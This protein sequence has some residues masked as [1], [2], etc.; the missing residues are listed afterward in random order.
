MVSIIFIYALFPLF[1]VPVHSIQY[2]TNTTVPSNISTA[3][4]QALIGDISCGEL[5]PFLNIGNYYTENVLEPFC[6]TDC[7]SA[8]GQYQLSIDEACGGE[9]WEGYSDNSSGDDSSEDDRLPIHV[10]PDVLRYLYNLTCLVDN[11][12]YCRVVALEKALSIGV[13]NAQSRKTKTDKQDNSTSASSAAG[14]ASNSSIDDC[15]LCFIKNLQLQ[16]A[17]PYYD[18]ADLATIY[19]SKTSSCGVTGYPLTT[20]TLD[21]PTSVLLYHRHTTVLSLITF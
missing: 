20:S 6:T 5:L 13:Y 11:G 16:A 1:C 7:S 21:L 19:S 12:R 17:V 15:D 9:T 2:L 8:L 10:I 14:G 3:C 4:S 18:G